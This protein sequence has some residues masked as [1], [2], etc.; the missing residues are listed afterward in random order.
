MPEYFNNKL[1]F[2]CN[3]TS[4]QKLRA[5][6]CDAIKLKQKCPSNN[7]DDSF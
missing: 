6:L 2:I 4:Q 7:D 1:Y 5:Y 3:K